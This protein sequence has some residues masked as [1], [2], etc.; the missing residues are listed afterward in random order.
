VH[1]D[2]ADLMNGFERETFGFTFKTIPLLSS[3]QKMHSIK[4][5]GST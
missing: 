5:C 1:P 3:A 4:F 2:F